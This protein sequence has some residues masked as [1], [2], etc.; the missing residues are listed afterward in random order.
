MASKS[1]VALIIMVVLMVA[2]VA[3]FLVHLRGM[4]VDAYKAEHAK[5]RAA[6][7]DHGMHGDDGCVCDKGYLGEKCDVMIPKSGDQWKVMRPDSKPITSEHDDSE[8]Q[9]VFTFDVISNDNDNSIMLVSRETRSD[10]DSEGVVSPSDKPYLSLRVIPTRVN[11]SKVNVSTNIFDDVSGNSIS[12]G[13]SN[14]VSSVKG[15]PGLPSEFSVMLGHPAHN[16]T[17]V[18]V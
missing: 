14:A 6:C 18:R 8:R 4:R 17:F 7:S 16:L 1:T 2:F 3:M 13:G 10:I 5:K 9:S 11:A 12:P 15:K